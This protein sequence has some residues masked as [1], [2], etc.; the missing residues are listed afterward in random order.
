MIF[1]MPSFPFSPNFNFGTTSLLTQVFTT[2]GVPFPPVAG[3][4]ELLD[5]TPMLLLDN[6]NFLLL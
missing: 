5:G 4:F 1:S 3:N 2:E 6:T